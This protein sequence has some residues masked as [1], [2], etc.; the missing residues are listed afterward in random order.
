M[1]LFHCLSLLSLLYFKGTDDKEIFLFTGYLQSFGEIEISAF[2]R[3]M[4][5]AVNASGECKWES[6]ITNTNLL[7]IT[8]IDVDMS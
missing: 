5:D 8:S 4:F 7:W 6:K 1:F 3:G 2:S